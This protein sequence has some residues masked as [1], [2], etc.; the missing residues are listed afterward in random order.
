V[1]I[2]DIFK[3]NKNRV[4][5]IDS[6]EEKSYSYFDFYNLI[7]NLSKSISDRV[8]I[9]KSEKIALYL[10]NSIYLAAL[11]FWAFFN[12]IK[13]F[14]ISK[15]TPIGQVYNILI[16]Y[17]I[18]TIISDVDLHNLD[19]S[20]LNIKD[21]S[22]SGRKYRLDSMPSIDYDTPILFLLTSG[23][24]GVPKCVAHNLSN[25]INNGTSFINM[26]NIGR[27]DR[28]VTLLEM[29]Y[30]AGFY[31]MFFLSFIAQSSVVIKPP[32][33]AG[34]IFSFWS[35]LKK[36]EVNIL[37]I[38]PSII[39]LLNQL[40]RDKEGAKYC[41]L[42]KYIFSCTANLSLQDKVDFSEKYTKNVY[43]TYGLSET[44]FVSS[45]KSDSHYNVDNYVGQPFPGVYID[46]KKIYIKSN[47]VF[48]GYY[49]PDSETLFKESSFNTG[50]TGFINNKG[51]FVTGRD[52]DIIIKGGIN[53]NP[54]ALESKFR[55][56]DF[57]KDI[58]IVGMKDDIFGEKPVCALTINSNIRVDYIKEMKEFSS[59][60]IPS[61][62]AIND[63]VILDSLPLNNNNKVDKFKVVEILL[64]R[65]E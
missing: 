7:M 10:D 3:S 63:F 5:I 19:V 4:F 27:N 53:I 32:F 35:E 14:P 41:Q 61:D 42:I 28:F 49:D 45:E 12:G 24:T 56:L 57:I 47:K 11:Y 37:W 21:L 20:S 50:D 40:D 18:S 54:R 62:S 30:M 43:N 52:K 16:E 59:Q 65:L 55:T 25:F 15:K 1:L 51:L 39:K 58:C 8:E 2:S 26:H 60:N 31:N 48:E 44:L 34:N 23:S 36:V 29:S 33:H 64:Q 17:K 38:V 13:I 9:N 6:V 46:N 22:L